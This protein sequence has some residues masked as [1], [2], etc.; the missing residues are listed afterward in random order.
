[1]RDLPNVL[2]KARIESILQR[3][4]HACDHYKEKAD[5][6]LVQL[7]PEMR[8]ETIE[9]FCVNHPSV[10]ESLLEHQ[11]LKKLSEFDFETMESSIEEEDD[12]DGNF[13][14]NEILVGVKRTHQEYTNELGP[15]F[16]L[17]EREGRSDVSIKLDP[18]RSVS[19]LGNY[20]L[21]APDNIMWQLNDDTHKR[22]L[23]EQVKDIITQLGAFQKHLEKKNNNQ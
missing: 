6:Q 20:K 22:Y 2:A 4:T 15:L 23:H 11:Q 3:V 1:M 19:E 14:D 21:V 12:D 7:S 16:I 8:Q 18:N 13:I 10:F 5:D 9:D 17:L